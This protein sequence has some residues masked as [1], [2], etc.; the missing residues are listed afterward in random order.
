MNPQE[1]EIKHALS[2]LPNNIQN[3]VNVFPWETKVPGITVKYNM[4][5]DE[6]S[7]FQQ[8]TMKVV[9]GLSSS[10]D[11]KKNLMKSLNINSNLAESLVFEANTHIF[12]ELQNLAFNRNNSSHD[13]IKEEM[14]TE[15]V[16]LID[17]DED[18]TVDD[19]HKKEVATEPEKKTIYHEE[20][21]EDDMTGIYGH[22]I[23]TTPSTKEKPDFSFEKK[24][25]KESHISKGD[26]LVITSLEKPSVLNSIKKTSS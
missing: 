9:V 25:S 24:V 8:E 12:K 6:A 26:K 5:I 11:Y 2:T 22:R 23:H 4:Q 3:A 7:V 14:K 15:G 16:H 20:I 17:H 10:Q 18:M 21:S 1:Q 19:P 13:E